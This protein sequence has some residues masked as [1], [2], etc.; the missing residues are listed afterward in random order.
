MWITHM[1]DHCYYKRLP[2]LL[3]NYLLVLQVFQIVPPDLRKQALVVVQRVGALGGQRCKCNTEALQNAVGRHRAHLQPTA[4]TLCCPCSLHCAVL[5]PPKPIICKKASTGWL[6]LT[7]W[8]SRIPGS[9]CTAVTL[10]QSLPCCQHPDH[11]KGLG[12]SCLIS[13]LPRF[14]THRPWVTLA[15]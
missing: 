6:L 14:L 4:T 13:P 9:S 12:L 7:E 8:K 15:S 3:P 1:H 10:R 2:L 11:K 5:L